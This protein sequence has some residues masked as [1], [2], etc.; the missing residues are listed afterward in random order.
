MIILNLLDALCP[1]L[2]GLPKDVLLKLKASLNEH[3]HNNEA[4]V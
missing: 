1:I 2:F 3:K 4:T